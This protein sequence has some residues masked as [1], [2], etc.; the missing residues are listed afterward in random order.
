MKIVVQYYTWLIWH[1]FKSII[2]SQYPIF[3]VPSNWFA[4][5]WTIV[6]LRLKSPPP[7]RTRCAGM[8]SQNGRPSQFPLQASSVR[9]SVFL[10]FLHFT[11]LNFFDRNCPPKKEITNLSAFI[12]LKF[13]P[14]MADIVSP[15]LKLK[16][17]YN[18]CR[19]RRQDVAQE[20]EGN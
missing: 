19:D 6:L 17:S 3:T 16:P 13:Q 8:P 18:I 5:S 9:C 11:F 12:W 14:N 20:M 4:I 1:F 10:N 15:E 2:V 7:S